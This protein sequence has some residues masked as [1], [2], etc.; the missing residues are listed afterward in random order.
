M[1]RFKPGDLVTCSESLE[2]TQPMT[3]VGLNPW[4]NDP[5]TVVYYVQ[6]LHTKKGN[7]LQITLEEGILQPA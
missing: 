7:T 5:R 1:P 6:G 2:I 4:H 3:I